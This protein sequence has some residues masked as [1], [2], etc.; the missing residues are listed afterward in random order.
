MIKFNHLQVAQAKYP[1]HFQCRPAVWEL[2][3]DSLLSFFDLSLT[4]GA[5]NG[6]GRGMPMPFPGGLPPPGN[7]PF[8]FPPPGGFPNAGGAP[9]GMPP[10]MPPG[11]N[12]MP[13]FPPFPL[14][15]QMNPMVGGFPPLM[16]ASGPPGAAASA[17]SGR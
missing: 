17:P 4:H 10:F 2:V 5:A 6:L 12:G 8:P 11:Q 9:N 16:G 14:P 15:N 3:S 13:A 7:L 1:H